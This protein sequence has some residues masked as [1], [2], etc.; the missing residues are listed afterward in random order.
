MK[1]YS[2]LNTMKKS[3]LEVWKADKNL[4][5]I[6]ALYTV[7]ATILPIAG[8]YMPRL[9]IEELEKSII[10]FDYLIVLIGSLTILI[11]V[12]GFFEKYIYNLTSVRIMSIRIDML[13]GIFDKTNRLDYHY[14]EDPDFLNENSDAYDVIGGNDF[15]EVIRRLFVSL[16]KIFLT[17]IYIFFLINLS[18]YVV[19]GIIVSV[20]VSIFSAFVVKRV[21]FKYKKDTTKANRKIRYFEQT[22]QDFSFGKD[23]RLYN[24]QDS[25]KES[26]DFEIKSYI[27]I[28]RKIKNKEYF[29]AF[30]D[31]IF[32]LIS[33]L[34]LYYFLIVRVIDGMDIASFSFY[35]LAALSLSTILKGIAEDVVYLISKGQLLN[36]YF[37]FMETEFNEKSEGITEVDAETL[38]IEFVDVSFKYPKTDK[39]IIK[40]LNL[41][42]NMGEKLAI[43]GING[44][45]K[46]TLVKLLLR[47]FNPTE[48]VILI[49]GI[50]AKKYEKEAYQRLFAPVFQDINILAFSIREN[51][52]FGLSNDEERIWESLD[53]VGLGD[54]V[55]NFEKGLDTI[56]LKNIDEKGIIL[57]GGE[58]QKLAIARALY[59]NSKMVVL[60]EPTAALD[61]LAEAEIYEN[62]NELVK[63]KTS[64][65]ISHRLASTK[66][67]DKIAL[68][69]NSGLL[70]Y[71]THDELMKLKGEY[72]NMFVIQGKYYQ[73]G[74]E[75]WAYLK[76]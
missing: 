41:K 47:M 30:I 52:T 22:S 20:V 23:I 73:N 27:S 1:K 54:K 74:E 38:E 45:G 28:L 29:L 66:F 18:I 46:T 56:L 63:S 43:V 60:D 15:E 49:N 9:I 76:E 31:L 3:V 26:Y 51:I 25:I 67:C 42:I 48:G 4:F 16:S 50:D 8:L 53:A 6:F 39:W 14:T 36:D 70:E 35:L 75:E 32:V 64:I 68:F 59:K 7:F 37:I 65:F 55:R 5:I 10:D 17:L 61:A 34:L 2:F 13:T 33:D 58:N 11:G 21:R 69:S 57:S 62:F 72:Y 12:I 44:A 24:F 71:G 40:N 19:L